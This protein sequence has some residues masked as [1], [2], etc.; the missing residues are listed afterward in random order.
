MIALR[1]AGSFEDLGQLR[2]VD[3]RGATTN[4]GSVQSYFD[5]TVSPDGRL[6]AVT[7]SAVKT[8]SAGIWILDAAGTARRLT[9]SREWEGYPVWSADGL[10]IAYV[11]WWR[12]EKAG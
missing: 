4:V 12:L 1:S 8:G 11:F 6:I 10:C 2:W 3:R 7:L 9:T 5:G